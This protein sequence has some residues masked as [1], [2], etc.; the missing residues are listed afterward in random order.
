MKKFTWWLRESK[1]KWVRTNLTSIAFMFT[2]FKYCRSFDIS[3]GVYFS[4]GFSI[5]FKFQIPFLFGIYF[6]IE[7]NEFLKNRFKTARKEDY[8]YINSIVIDD[9]CI[10]VYLLRRQ[11]WDS[12][13]ERGIMKFF[14][15]TDVIYGKC[16]DTVEKNGKLHKFSFD[17][18]DKLNHQEED[19]TWAAKDITLTVEVQEIERIMKM[20]RF[21]CRKVKAYVLSTDKQIT[22]FGKGDNGWDCD[23]G[24]MGGVGVVYIGSPTTTPKEEADKYVAKIKQRQGGYYG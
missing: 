4:D 7:F 11:S 22:I 8:S 1:F 14:N 17:I 5:S 10:A 18:V 20:Q 6:S 19:G 3:L 13:K 2:W 12:S 23:M 24:T 16:K 15:W 9:S 21:G